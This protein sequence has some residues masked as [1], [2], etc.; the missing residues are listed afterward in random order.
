MLNP[1]VTFIQQIYLLIILWISKK[2][3]SNNGRTISTAERTV[4][5]LNSPLEQD[6]QAAIDWFRINEMTVN[7][8]KF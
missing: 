3:L 7:P 1:W 6:S 5:K 8:D 4:E 2:D